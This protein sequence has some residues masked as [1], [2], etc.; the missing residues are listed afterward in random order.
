MNRETEEIYWIGQDLA[1]GKIGADEFVRK[2]QSI[3]NKVKKEAFEAGRKSRPDK[4]RKNK[5]V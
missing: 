2:M 3:F 5:G 1:V 4:P